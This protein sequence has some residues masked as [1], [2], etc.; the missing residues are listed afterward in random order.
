MTEQAIRL[1]LVD[2]HAVVRTGYRALLEQAAG[3][4]ICGEAADGEQAYRL[5]CETDPDAVVM[6]INLPGLSGLEAT[7]RIMARS[8]TARVLIFSMHEDMVFVEQAMQA[9]ALGYIPK[10]SDPDTL[11]EAIRAVANGR[12]FVAASIA[13]RRASHMKKAGDQPFE[14]FSTREFEI[15]C[16]LAE[17]LTTAAVGERLC[18]SNKTVANY[19][20]Q[21]KSKLQ[22]KSN[23][24]LVHLAIRGGIISPT[25]DPSIDGR[26]SAESE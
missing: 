25:V 8:T 6:D 14:D 17:G 22:V 10:S 5:F 12:E 16:L 23:T 21:I 2:D 13:R 20:T 19:A 18:I 9:G 3:I 11:L 24:E 26:H 1:L 4:E 7:R 15:F